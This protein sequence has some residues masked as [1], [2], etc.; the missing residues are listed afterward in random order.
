MLVK[1]SDVV[2]EPVARDGITG[3]GKWETSRKKLVNE[4]KPLEKNMILPA[5]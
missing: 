2:S 1:Q 4:K 3:I 5:L